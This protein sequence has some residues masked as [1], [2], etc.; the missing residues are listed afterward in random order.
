MH[1][2]SGLGQGGG[3]ASLYKL[4]KE[5]SGI[6]HIVISMTDEGV[7]AER[8]R[9]LGIEVHHLNISG[10][11]DALVKLFKLRDFLKHNKVDAVQTWM[12]HAD[13]YGGIAAKM[14]GI[15]N[16]FWGLRHGVVDAAITKNRT[17]L[18]VRLNAILSR[19]I[20]KLVISCSAVGVINHAA[21]GYA[22]DRMVVIPN[23]VDPNVFL[24][25]SPSLSLSDLGCDIPSQVPLL[26]MVARYD[27]Y[28]DHE[29]LLDSLEILR[30][31]GISFHFLLIGYGIT[32][33]NSELVTALEQRDLTSF[34]SL[35]GPRS[36]INEVMKV[37]DMF[38]LSSRGEAFPN[39]LVEAMA[40][41]VPCITTDVGDA[42]AIVADTGWIIPS[43]NPREL[44][45]A[46][47]MGLKEMRR[48][49]AWVVRKRRCSE[50]VL[51][52]Y[53]LQHMA[54]A[55]LNLWVGSKP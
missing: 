15:K 46:I 32:Y 11:G 31:E 13:L 10:W 3:E 9:S 34:V 29:N 6:S 25:Q 20:P 55:Y 45:A 1:I 41:G 23:G 22:T 28:K 53:S 4:C 48:E 27:P 33:L 38:V 16:I 7:F 35:I 30:N 40:C 39:V 19:F 49:N 42:A 47:K 21:L 14:A 18:I 24:P 12:Y 26:G 50:R 2:I 43:R 17:L 54:Q 44:A 37:L 51:R 36:D 8:L 52:E 5:C